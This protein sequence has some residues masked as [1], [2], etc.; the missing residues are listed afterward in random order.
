M[1]SALSTAALL[2]AWEIAE[3]RSPLDRPLV[4]L[5]ASDGGTAAAAL[6]DLPLVER[7]RRLL[8]LRR[9]MFGDLMPCVTECPSCGQ[10][11]EIEASAE[12]LAAALPSPQAESVA[13]G[14]QQLTLT[15]PSPAAM[16]PRPS[17]MAAMWTRRWCADPLAS[18]RCRT[19]PCW[20][21]PL[22]GCG[23]C[24]RRQSFALP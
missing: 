10:R 24:K 5:W 15:P 21:P 16:S 22:H 9:A 19:P 2:R 8:V 23:R 1:T 20:P 11:L 6:A 14:D 4:L 7:D 12:A 3:S 18:S 17:L 13:L